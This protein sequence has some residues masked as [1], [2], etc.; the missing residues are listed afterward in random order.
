MPTSSHTPSPKPA[1]RQASGPPRNMITKER[2]VDVALQQI[3]AVGLHAF[4][5]RDVAR[6]LGVYP[7]TV[8]WHVDS[9]NALL[10]EVASRVM[11][12]VVPARD[13]LDWKDWLRAL[14]F[15]YRHA[16]QAHPHVAQLI[17]A[18]LV[19]NGS[20]STTLIEGVL[21]ALLDAG[22]A[23]D[24]LADAY[25]CVIAALSGFMTMELAPLP[26]EDAKGWADAMQARV[27]ATDA[28]AHPM[29]ARYLPL[30]ANRAFILRWQD[31]R[32]APM[33]SGF[34]AHVEIFLSGLLAFLAA[35]VPVAPAAATAPSRSRRRK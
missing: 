30:L 11:A 29:L 23:E 21:Q 25:N 24:R 20:L 28:L 18:Q 32:D 2:I 4:S 17:G 9:R 6:S 5:L 35:S 27:R 12:E 22:A 33:D 1:R 15:R 31:G 19:S 26:Q 10:A 13:G 34:A 3:D 8:Y 7:T 14:F 16:M